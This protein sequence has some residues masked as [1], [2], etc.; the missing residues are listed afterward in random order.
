MGAVVHPFGRA[1]RR[2]SPGREPAPGAA[3]HSACAT[4]CPRRRWSVP[5]ATAGDQAESEEQ[6]RQTE[7]APQ[8]QPG[9]WRRSAAERPR[10]LRPGRPAGRG[11]CR[12]TGRAG[13][14][15]RGPR[16]R[17]VAGGVARTARPWSRPGSRPGL[18]R[19]VRLV[20]AATRDT[21][22]RGVAVAEDGDLV[23]RGVDGASRSG[24]SGCPIRCRPGRWWCRR[25]SPGGGV[26][27]VIGG[28]AGVAVADHGDLVAGR[29]DRGGG[30][31]GGL[32][33]RAG[34]VLRRWWC[35]RSELPAAP[36]GAVVELAW[37]PSPMTVTWLPEPSTGTVAAASVWLP[38]PVPS[39][40]WWCRRRS[41]PRRFR[42]VVPSVELVSLPSPMTV[43]WLPEASTGAAAPAR[44]GCP[45]RCRPRPWWCR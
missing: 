42:P 20:G 23:V 43:T 41:S 1:T 25:R 2:C 35:R 44:S 9:G 17:A 26:A 39:A 19:L 34:A 7:E 33:P 45:I 15:P 28:V 32:V 38:E 22:V 13:R 40:P 12:A 14:A 37:L 24:R 31:R 16:S 27:G 18:A 8:Q 5:S 36:F 4:P 21:A 6:D 29:V 30:G 3:A 10:R 11:G